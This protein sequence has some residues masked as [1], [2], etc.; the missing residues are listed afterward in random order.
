M[1]QKA[2]CRA[3][4]FV[5]AVLVCCQP[6][7]SVARADVGDDSNTSREVIGWVVP[8]TTHPDM[9]VPYLLT[10]KAGSVYFYL[11][12]STDTQLSQFANKRVRV[13]GSEFNLENSRT[14]M[15]EV[16][17]VGPP[18]V[19]LRRQAAPKREVAAKRA[20]APQHMASATGNRKPQQSP[21]EEVV[22]ASFSEKLASA[23][24]D[25]PGPIRNTFG[26]VGLTPTPM[27]DPE[28]QRAD[29][30]DQESDDCG[31]CGDES[32][33][34]CCP[35]CGL[36]G[37]FW[38]RT[39]Y[40]YWWT[41]GMNLPPLVTTGPSAN[42]P[43]Y[44]GSPGTVILFGDSRVNDFGRSGGRITAGMWLDACHEVGI[45]GDY[46]A[47]A[48]VSTNYSA[49]S[50][51]DPILSR[52]FFDTRPD[53]NAPNVE[54]VASP[55]SIAGTVAVNVPTQFQSA[56][57]NLLVNLC[58]C[59]ECFCDA[60]L[61]GMNGPG[62]CRVDFMIGYRFYR[63]SDG[64]DITE[65]LA[66]LDPTAP[67]SF[68][69]NDSFSSQTQ[70]HGVEFGTSMQ[71]FRGLWGFE[72]ISRIA[73]GNNT[74]YVTINGSTQTTQNGV[75]TTDTGGLLAQTSN[76]GN[77]RRDQF[78]VVPQIGLNLLYQFT[79]GLRATLGYTFV[80][81]SRVVRAGD[82]IDTDVNS[83]LL[84][85]NPTPPTGDLRHPQFVF[86]D[87]DFWAQGISVGLEYRW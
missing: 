77:Y 54:Q 61:P 10:D 52:P 65:T 2:V 20:T 75:T 37:Q 7:S 24:E 26:E 41:Q 14:P 21:A 15:L 19:A 73:M 4:P 63:L 84:P 71:T 82:Q 57:V 39:E 42:Q 8:N 36:P 69:V 56:G 46:F 74:E 5:I 17:Q 9:G 55:G 18:D 60:C 43:G 51:G 62:G 27:P 6:W 11:R 58:C 72:A 49:T 3:L 78:A 32:C 31:D 70:F 85:N 13:R 1:S 12:P 22:P 66:S 83:T 76:I 81:W 48:S 47:L 40:L 23:T 45:Q 68:I 59:N 53:L 44:I 30:L 29:F 50:G 34:A 38:V 67:G 28:H 87:T 16:E 64:V 35:P 33:E 25:A 79:P 86:R 80:Y